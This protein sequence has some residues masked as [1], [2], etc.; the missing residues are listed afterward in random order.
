MKVEA[1][2][3]AAKAEWR[4]Q[5]KN[6]LRTSMDVSS[7]NTVP[8]AMTMTFFQVKKRVRKPIG[9]PNRILLEMVHV[10]RHNSSTLLLK[11][12]HKD[13]LTRLLGL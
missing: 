10:S 4:E 13:R 7:C 1:N 6:K 5:G 9:G 12:K 11:W 8:S 2:C 3:R